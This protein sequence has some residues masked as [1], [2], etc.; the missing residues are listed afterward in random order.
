MATTIDI[1]NWALGWVGTGTVLASERENRPEAVACRLH[2]DSARRQALR[3]YPWA[4][5]QTRAVLAEKEV[6]EAWAGEWR[7][8]YAVPDL[9]L[10]AIR[11]GK[12]GDRDAQPFVVVRDPEGRELIL[13]NADHALLDY[14]T[15]EKDATRFDDSF[16]QILGRKLA[17][18][19]AIS[20]LKNNPN[21][22]TE[23]E[24]VYERY[25]HVA[26]DNDS[27]ERKDRETADSWLLAREGWA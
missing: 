20:L 27:A 24:Q 8:A 19:I 15:D 22:V 26:H 21:K 14:T 25:L 3:D 17:C 5:A 12:P 11:V 6:P 2:W 1:W 13:T 16:A 7:H 4:F 18:M 9:C 23:L 10:K